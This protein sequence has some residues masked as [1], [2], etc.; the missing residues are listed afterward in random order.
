LPA[1]L[2]PHAIT[3]LAWDPVADEVVVALKKVAEEHVGQFVDALGRSEPAVRR[4]PAP[5][6]RL[7]VCVSHRAADALLIG[8][9]D[10]RSRYGSIAAVACPPSRG[11]YCVRAPSTRPW[12][13]GIHPRDK[14]WTSDGTSWEGN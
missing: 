10:L 9:G 12:M 2:V 7:C 1:T 13:F 6:S 3:L 8:L 14:R 5:R 4:A 11:P